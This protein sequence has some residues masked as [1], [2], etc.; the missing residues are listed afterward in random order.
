M[1]RILVT[2]GA[3]S[4]IHSW[5]G[6]HGATYF[7]ATSKKSFFPQIQ[8]NFVIWFDYRAH[9]TSSSWTLWESVAL[10][11]LCPPPW[12]SS[13]G[14]D[15][16]PWHYCK[17]ELNVNI[18]REQWNWGNS[19]SLQVLWRSW[20]PW[21]ST[22]LTIMEAWLAG[23]WGATRLQSSSMPGL[24]MSNWPGRSPGTQVLAPGFTSSRTEVLVRFV[25][26]FKSLR[27]APSH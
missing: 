12:P 25:T 21:T 27:S 26:F 17:K 10:G 22:A 8:L 24:W 14:R 15:I 6:G 3:R 9:Q 20:Q 23:I 13:W 7:G 16:E 2:V 19:S 5:L 1:S 11:L 18:Y 4:Y